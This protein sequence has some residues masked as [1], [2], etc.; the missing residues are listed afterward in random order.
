[1][2]RHVTPASLMRSSWHRGPT[3]GIGR[4][5]GIL[6]S[7]ALCNFR[8]RN[9]SSSMAVGENGGVVT[10]PWSQISSLSVAFIRSDYMS[11]QTYRQVNLSANV[12]TAASS[13]PSVPA[14]PCDKTYPL[15]LGER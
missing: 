11:Y 3:A 7:S 12:L 13:W 14:L 15:H 1:M 4:E 6:S 5:W 8:R 9:P 10:S 2:I